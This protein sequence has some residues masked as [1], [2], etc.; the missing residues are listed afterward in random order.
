MEEIEHHCAGS[1]LIQY[2]GGH[3]PSPAN[4]CHL[5]GTVK[6]AISSS[7]LLLCN[8]EHGKSVNSMNLGP[9][10]HFICYEVSSLIRNNVLNYC[11][12]E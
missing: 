9:L 6:E 2:P 8:R 11:Y 12:D 10:L 3:C 5:G 1:E 7:Q 4:Y